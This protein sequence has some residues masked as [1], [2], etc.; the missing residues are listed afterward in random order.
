MT[1]FIRSF[2]ILAYRIQCSS[3]WTLNTY[4]GRRRV[5]LCINLSHL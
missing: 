4:I 5:S 3:I 2:I 1:K